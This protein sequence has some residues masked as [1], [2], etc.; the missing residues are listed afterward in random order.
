MRRSLFLLA[1]LLLL[2]STAPLVASADDDL[3]KP[4]L[5]LPP[6][7]TFVRGSVISEMVPSDTWGGL[8]PTGVQMFTQ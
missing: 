1:C 8:G 6:R 3:T 7:A 2:L 4:S 5:N